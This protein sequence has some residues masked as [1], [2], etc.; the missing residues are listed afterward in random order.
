MTQ[1]NRMHK[2]MLLISLIAFII[3]GSFSP[4][5]AANKRKEKKLPMVT[6]ETAKGNIIFEM[7]PDVAPKTVARITEL[8][9]KGF[10][11]GLTFHRVV[12]GFVIQGGDPRGDGTGGS[13]VKLLAE[14]SKMKHVTG[15]VA[16]ARAQD[17]NSADSQF[18]ICLADQPGL[19]GQYTIFGQV[20]DKASLDVIQKI[21]VGDV[22]KKVT[23]Q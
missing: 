14:F 3:G 7:Y 1:W 4:L 6:I 20:K 17:P 13:G 8:I 2:G 22:M 15:T 23:V 16:M 9:K 21:R 5:M 11:N 18:Y 10:Y 19:D 12:P